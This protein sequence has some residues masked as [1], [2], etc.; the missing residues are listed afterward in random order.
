MRV[1]EVQC[2][3]LIFVHRSR[4]ESIRYN[5]SSQVTLVSLD[6]DDDDDDDE[7]EEDED[8]EDDADDEGV[9]ER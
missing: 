9:D 5:A 8:E 3:S 6:D 4:N 7:D 1:V 2:R